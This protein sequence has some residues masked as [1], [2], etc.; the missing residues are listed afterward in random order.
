MKILISVILTLIA[1]MFIL[2]GF[3]EGQARIEDCL[4]ESNKYLVEIK[5]NKRCLIPLVCS[6]REKKKNI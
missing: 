4:I 1:I 6:Y 5:L 3:K 2:S